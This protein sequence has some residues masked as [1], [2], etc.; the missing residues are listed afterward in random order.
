MK[1]DDVKLTVDDRTYKA[2]RYIQNEEKL[3]SIDETLRFLLKK[4]LEKTK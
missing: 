2:L 1:E 4:Q 3:D